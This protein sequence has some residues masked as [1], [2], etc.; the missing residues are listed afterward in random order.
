MFSLILILILRLR[1]SQKPMSVLIKEVKFDVY[2]AD[3]E[4]KRS[5]GLSIYNSLPH[6]RGMIFDFGK[7]DIY[8]TFWMKD[9]KFAL[10]IIWIN[11]EK[12]V[13]IDENVP[14][15]P[16]NTPDNKLTLYPSNI[17]IDYVL[18]V[19]S[20]LSDRYGFKIGDSVTFVK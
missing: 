14:T 17:P 10:D 11:D 9:M 8:A 4:E 1:L 6:D 2:V 15:P 20:G 19:N 3:T 16:V 7:K 18:E 5:K 13:K 12:I